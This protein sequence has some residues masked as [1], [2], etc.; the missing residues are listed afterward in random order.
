MIPLVVG[1]ITS[2]YPCSSTHDRLLDIVHSFEPFDIV[3]LQEVFG[4]IY[5]EIREQF[6][7]YS[8]KAGFFHVVS[9][10]D[11]QYASTYFGDGG[12]VILSRF[13]IVKTSHCEYSY[14]YETD[15][16]VQRGVLY[17]KIET[18]P[19]CFVNMFTTHMNSTRYKPDTDLGP[20][21]LR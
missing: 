20:D 16:M 3:C 6:I 19:K 17:A 7:Q 10:E 21:L 8:V 4:G 13:P 14:S 9:D 11:P 18:E 15:G 12:L 5:S 1:M 2:T